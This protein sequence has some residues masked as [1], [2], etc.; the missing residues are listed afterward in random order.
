MQHFSLLDYLKN[1]TSIDKEILECLKFDLDQ[2]IYYYGQH[3]KY[4]NENL[5]D[6]IT[7][8]NW[9][10]QKAIHVKKIIN[11]FGSKRNFKPDLNLKSIFSNAY[12]NFNE[13][14]KKIGF[15]V[16]HPFWVN[17]E[18][19]PSSNP[20]LF[21][22]IKEVKQSLAEKTFTELIDPGFISFIKNMKEK[23]K[24]YYLENKIDAL[25]V[26]ND[27]SF[28]ENLSIKIFNE[29]NKPNFVFLHGIPARYS[30]ADDNHPKYL[31]VWGE[32]IKEHY[33]KAGWDAK[34]IL[35]SG[36]PTYQNFQQ[37]QL[38]FDYQNILIITK[39]M[40]GN[41][42]ND[43]VR[44]ADRGNLI[45]Y[46]NSIQKVLLKLGVKSVKFRPHPSENGAW[47]QKY[48]DN[49]FFKLDTGSFA[50]SVQK[51]TLIIGPTSTTFIE[52]IYYGTNYVVY[53]PLFDNADLIN[54][55]VD[56]PFDGKDP[57]VPV[58]KD[59]EELYRILKNKESV[60]LGIFPDYIKIPFDIGF[61]KDYI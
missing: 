10:I 18:N 9:I 13:E 48:I 44:L 38:R 22:D 14:L 4:S 20:N 29:I 40:T 35:V 52:S 42:L 55:P 59:E 31:I 11:S 2:R 56:S 37:K 46:L 5:G 17:Q 3:F 12:F 7:L 6:R 32:K 21:Q 43:G 15:N 50:E 49:S 39:S 54:Y 30:V 34:R 28:F 19:L 57:R 16:F 33:V 53:E 58:A 45:Y 41:Q 60:D 23:M 24:N 47:Y 36:H 1:N 61:L 51:S 25:I 26:P 8:M 27:M